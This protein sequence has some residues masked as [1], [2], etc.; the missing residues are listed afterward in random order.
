MNPRSARPALV[1]DRLCVVLGGVPVLRDVSLS[2][3]AG[4]TVALIGRNGAGKTTTMRSI[5]G[6]VQSKSGRLQLG[7]QGL[8]GLPAYQRARLG[9]GYVPEDRRMVGA[10]SVEDNI[11]LPAHACK[12]DAADRKSVV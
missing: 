8:D 9:M 3:P 2:V 7:E 1:I 5:L 11:L 4:R 12:L 6:H 10:L